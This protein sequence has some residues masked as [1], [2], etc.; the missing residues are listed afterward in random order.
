MTYSSLVCPEDIQNLPVLGM[1]YVTYVSYGYPTAR[2]PAAAQL[3]C[4]TKAI[5]PRPVINYVQD[6]SEGCPPLS[7]VK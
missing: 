2:V 1:Y 5:R 3:H 7:H 6:A 4:E